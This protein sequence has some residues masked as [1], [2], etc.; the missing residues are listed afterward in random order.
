MFGARG[1]SRAAVKGNIRSIPSVKHISPARS[2]S[3]IASRPVLAS[4]PGARL[5]LK[6]SSFLPPASVSGLSYARFNSTSSAASGTPEATENV[7]PEFED[8]IPKIE[9]IPERIG[10]LKE[11]GLDFGWGPSAFM[12]WT[13]EH[14]HILSGMPWWASIVVAGVLTRLALFKPSLMAA[15]NAAKTAPV[16]DQ[17]LILRKQRLNFMSQG[18]QLEA[19]KAKVEMDDLYKNNGIAMW[20]SFMPLLQVPLGF[21]TFRVVRGMSLLPV[22]ALATEEFAWI[23]DLTSYDPLYVMPA[24]TTAFMYMALR[25]GTSGGANDLQATSLGRSFTMGLPAISL[26]F[27]MWQPAALQLYFATSGFFALVQA[28]LL[29]TPSTRSWLGVAPI[30]KV[31]PTA[32]ALAASGIRMISKEELIAQLRKQQQEQTGGTTSSSEIS[33][34]STKPENISI[35]DKM[36]NNAKK[37]FSSMKKEMN[38]KVEEFTGNNSANPD[39]TPRAKPRLTEAEQADAN[40][41]KSVREID[42]ARI[43]AEDNRRRVEE[44]SRYEAEQRQTVNSWQDI[45]R[46]AKEAAAAATANSS[47]SSKSRTKSKGRK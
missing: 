10:Y 36:V 39:G 26:L 2:L 40:S 7:L 35:I 42:D 13:I 3:S 24:L 43:M 14:L 18:K 38:N 15:D 44:Y 17:M 9:D 32:D 4:S 28:Y 41:Y 11:L 12:E 23:H 31:Q 45:R 21:G 27:I 34:S 1:L 46:K 20:K 29:N 16:R 30:K 47:G 6:A 5:R 25:K 22:P 33:A 19:A 8:L 37:E